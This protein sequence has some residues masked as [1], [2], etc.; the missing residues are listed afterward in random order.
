MSGW[1]VRKYRITY[2]L[3]YLNTLTLCTQAWR[4]EFRLRSGR[5]TVTTT[6][7]KQR[8]AGR[9]VGSGRYRICPLNTRKL[10]YR[11]D[12][13][14]MRPMVPWKFSSL[15]VRPQL[16]S[17]TFLMDFCSN[18]WSILRSTN[19][20][21]KFEVRR[22]LQ[23]GGDFL[24][25]TVYYKRSHLT[26]SICCYGNL[27]LVC[28]FT[29]SHSPAYVSKCLSTSEGISSTGRDFVLQHFR[30]DSVQGGLCPGF[31][32]ITDY[33]NYAWGAVLHTGPFRFPP[34]LK[35]SP[36]KGEERYFYNSYLIQI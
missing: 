22:K 2:S 35:I 21:T 9:S 17:P 4:V 12:D 10:S 29:E 36:H 19:V 11:K 14:A 18:Q 24:T 20:R 25:H 15:W 1:N 26:M 23:G 3:S 5:T 33:H 7:T 13:R 16:L 6:A 34:N 28:D 8:G 32:Q 27:G 31:W 30:G